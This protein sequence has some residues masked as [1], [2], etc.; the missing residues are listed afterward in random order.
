MAVIAAAVAVGLAGVG[1][2][3]YVVE[4]QRILASTDVLL[5]NNLEAAQVLVDAHVADDPTATA[6]DALRV[7][8][9]RVGPDDNMGVLGIV[10][11]EGVLVPGVELD[12]QL[13][14][15]PGFV[16]HVTAEANGSDAV[17]GRYAADDVVWQYL[18][19]PI[20]LSD[21]QSDDVL[22]VMGYDLE[23][24]LAE[25]NEPGRAYLAASAVAIL[26]VIA[27]GALAAGRLLRP[28][29]QMRETA[30]RVSGQELD[31]RLPVE[32][33]DDVSELA[34]TMN[35][36]LDRLD[37]ALDSQRQLLSDVRHELRTPI[38]I[39]RGHLEL[40][41]PDDAAEVR[42][43]QELAVD[44]LDRMN[45]LV[46]DLSES[47]S[48]HG[49]AA[50]QRAEPI[51]VR[52]LLV[53]IVRKADAL[54]GAQ[55]SA[56]PGVT[57]V[58]PLD[59]S[60]ITQAVLQLAQN[61]VTHGG[62]QIGHRQPPRWRHARGVGARP[63]G[64]GVPDEEKAHIFERFRR[65]AGS[66]RGSGLGLSIVQM[67]ARAHGGSA[68]VVDPRTGPGSVVRAVAAAADPGCAD[69]ARSAE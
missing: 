50:I 62:G 65:G 33:R 31:E 57:V 9:Q 30:E 1:G 53:Q 17:L 25:I 3:V 2:A 60:R 37:Q 7:V 28:L 38:T 8:V 19:A 58:A 64:A 21:D 55:V 42:E 66:G 52:E 47:A 39:V 61:A 4:R 26:L 35:D 67:I 27:V 40:L 10:N 41:N 22:F 56:G 43:T 59:E 6:S 69:R 11:G 49:R 13:E 23:A 16:D 15:Q 14:S 45:A 51:D 18:A 20:R 12:V 34:R 36:M 5:Q 24:E 46:Q 32:G 48:L 44:E 54:D 68:R 63:P 29:R